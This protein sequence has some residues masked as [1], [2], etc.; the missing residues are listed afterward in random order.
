[1]KTVI[2][3]EK[4]N[5]AKD[6]ATALELNH[7]TRLESGFF[8][9]EKDGTDFIITYT[10]GHCAR[11][12]EPEEIDEKYKKWNLDT[13]P[14]PFS[15]E[16]LKPLDDKKKIVR[17]IKQ[18]LKDADIVINAG[19]AGREGELIQR[20]A[21]K[22][23][24]YKGEVGRLWASSLSKNAIKEAY[25]NIIGYT[26]EEESRLDALYQAGEAR[27]V[28]DKYL[29]YNYSRLLS[30]AKTDGVTV[31]FGRCKTPLVHA[32]IERD[33]EVNN[34]VKRTFYFIKIKL[35]D[36][37]DAIYVDEKLNRV[38]FD[39]LE[40]AKTI[41]AELNSQADI[42]SVKTEDKKTNP[43]MPFDI[44]NIQKAM[45]KKYGFEADKTLELCQSLYDHHK[46]LSYPRTD[47]RYLT[48]DLMDSIHQN[49]E[50]LNFGKFSEF[51]KLAEGRSIPKKYFNDKKVA[52]HHGL[53][54]IVPD[55]PMHEKYEELSDDERKVFDEIA[56]NFISLFLPPFEYTLT[57][58]VSKVGDKLFLTKVKEITEIG[59]KCC[60]A[61]DEA[62]EDNDIEESVFSGL[63]E[64]KTLSVSEKTAE[65][66]ETKPK[67][68]Y[69]TETLLD[70]M[71]IHNIG[72]GATRDKLIKELTERKG[73][74][75]D[76]SVEKKGKHFIATDFGRDMD[77]L[78]PE[79]LKAISF[80]SE[81]DEGLSSIEKGEISKDNFL[82]EIRGMFLRDYRQMCEHKDTLMKNEKKVNVLDLTC[83]VCQKPLRDNSWGYSCTG[84]KKDNTGCNF[85][86]PKEVAGK[87]LPIK[88][89]KDL[90]LDGTTSKKVSGFKSKKGT[91]FDAYLRLEI[92]NGKGKISF[93]FKKND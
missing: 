54:P 7:L 75:K 27:A 30:L 42:V 15:E 28:M 19:D 50:V 90:L 68:H 37:L 70:F 10:Q 91:K 44:L 67:A 69:T 35:E 34:F 52:D 51:V 40:E 1:M 66:A 16:E 80:L 20:W 14:I 22:L 73:R 59:Y 63:K 77:A 32:I 87:K 76:S 64:E 85:S 81:L 31:N 83:P 11:L 48:T 65:K 61:E 46:I 86:I 17:G 4:A 5:A 25:E 55:Y 24:G 23:S 39:S 3:A 2:M 49:L 79:E 58:A 71:K 33:D 88:A 13:L 56:W 78:I 36:T 84:W 89:V 45:S 74:N 53:I 12:K 57:T 60:Y 72:T 26:N 82:D 38:E 9:G 41:V 47:S 62:E 92:E 18:C 93:D 21:V 6:I 43:P 29:G 8:A